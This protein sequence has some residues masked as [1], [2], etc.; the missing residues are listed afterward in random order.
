MVGDNDAVMV[1]RAGEAVMG[2]VKAA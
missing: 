2:W 1:G